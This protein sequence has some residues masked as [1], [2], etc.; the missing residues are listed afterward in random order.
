MTSPPP[1]PNRNG[2]NHNHNNNFSIKDFS[3]K[4]ASTI[5]KTSYLLKKSLNGSR[6][7]EFHEDEDIRGG[8]TGHTF[9]VEDISA[10]I[11]N[12]DDVEKNSNN[13]NNNNLLNTAV[14]SLSSPTYN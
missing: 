12:R 10:I 8:D 1:K 6:E 2:N 5:N 11:L 4:H 3:P 13:A 9:D 7:E 14:H